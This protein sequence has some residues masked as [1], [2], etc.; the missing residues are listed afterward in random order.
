MKKDFINS[1]KIII[2]GLV[3]SLGIGYLSAWYSPT[4]TPPNGNI[5]VPINNSSTPQAKCGNSQP[6]SPI[7]G[8]LLDI[9]GTL[10]A[11]S[12]GVFG[13]MTV[14]GTVQSASFVGT[15]GNRPICA[16]GSKTAT[17]CS[18][19]STYAL[20]V[21]KSGTGASVG[22]VTASPS[23]ISCGSTCSS[24]YVAGTP[25]TLTA[26][27]GS[28]NI[29]NGWS[30]GGC[31]GTGNCIVTMNAATTVTA[32]F[33]S[34]VPTYVLS[35]TKSGTGA[36]TVT[37]SPAGINCGS[38][39][40]ASYTSG[41]LVTLTA[42]PTSGTF[43]GWSGGGCSGT[44]TCNV[45]LSAATTVTATFAPA[46]TYTLS[47]TKSGTGSGTVTSNTGGINCG[48]TCSA[49]YTSGTSVTLT[50]SP[51][52]GTFT[53][54]SGGGCSGAG[55]CNVT[56]S[57]ATTVTATFT[58]TASVPTVVSGTTSYSYITNNSA[59]IN[60]NNVTA[61]NGA[62]VTARG[63][64]YNHINGPVS[65]NTVASGTT[66]TG[67]YTQTLTGL[68]PDTMYIYRAYA[69]NSAGSGYGDTINGFTTRKDAYVLTVTKVGSGTVTSSPGG[70]SC[71]STCAYTYNYG[72]S[73]ALTAAASGG[74][75]TGWSGACTGTGTCTVLMTDVRNVTATFT[76]PIY[77]LSITKSGTGSG[78]VTSNT[79]GINCGSTCSYNYVTGTAVIL[80]ATPTN[81]STFSGWSGG[82]CSGVATTCTV[83]M[84]S[85][86]TVTA[87]FGTPAC[88]GYPS[89]GYCW[90][91]SGASTLN[92]SCTQI[93]ST[94]GAICAAGNWDDDTSCSVQG[95]FGKVGS[96][97]SASASY[98]TFYPVSWPY[99]ND[100]RRRGSIAS[101]DCTAV[102]PWGGNRLCACSF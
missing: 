26:V 25:V 59:I 48:S 23:G 65:Q 70:I 62:A 91:M 39:C 86:N 67:L 68:F 88:S 40:S 102:V 100:R 75:F 6:C 56:V 9:N 71:G 29:F 45:T 53:G 64:Q 49:S 57:A 17:L 47:I 50:A 101:Q 19:S 60:N 12:L 22:S 32:T 95:H 98:E 61:D 82:G 99:P 73:I 10:T 52:S 5:A 72:T 78:T 28:N 66:G 31:S 38:T 14:G 54:W 16:N 74:T 43:T 35:I 76:A 51:I 4:Q 13:N 81:G 36:G 90:Y 42:T 8:D 37:S 93:C 94:H 80:T 87:G 7:S 24:G 11:Q 18:G 33:T 84:S 58:T 3:L 20:T 1:I 44:S 83:T 97:L 89:G 77:A 27:Q 46:P 34:N 55:T 63:L 2:L 15:T 92:Q 96:C 30:G 21:T 41:T 69:N 79:G 85:A